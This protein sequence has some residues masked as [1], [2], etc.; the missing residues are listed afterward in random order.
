[1]E[2]IYAIDTDF[3]DQN[4]D[5]PDTSASGNNESEADEFRSRKY[6]F[7]INN[8]SDTQYDNFF[9]LAAKATKWIIGK[10][11][12]EMGTPHL[13]GYVEFKNARYRRSIKKDITGE[14]WIKGAKKSYENNY[15]YCSKQGDFKCS[16]QLRT[17]DYIKWLKQLTLLPHQQRGYDIFTQPIDFFD[18]TVYWVYDE[19]G[20]SG[21]T[22]LSK[23]IRATRDDAIRINGKMNDVFNEILKY[24]TRN[25][26]E[27]PSIV[28]IDIPRSTEE[29]FINYT[30]IE[31][32]K[33]MD[34]MS[35]K[36]EGGDVLGPPPVLVI[37]S[38]HL[39]DKS[40]MTENR[41]VILNK[42]YEVIKF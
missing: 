25:D 16:R 40:K 9:K 24:K 14:F 10:E 6:V 30:T 37:F 11:V 28:L 2:N 21:K 38:N 3:E 23:Y 22:V 31:K 20:S 35:G 41:W 4:S 32:V 17:Q 29:K 1:M 13:Q 27:C 33:D 26:G 34:F 18:R 36:F 42:N 7:T 19:E 8:Y 15:Q 12:G 39:P 5:T